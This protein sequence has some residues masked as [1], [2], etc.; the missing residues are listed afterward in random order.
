MLTAVTGHRGFIGSWLMPR[1]P[2]P[3]IGLDILEGND[4]LTCPLPDADLVIHL[5]AQPGVIASMEDPARTMLQN[6]TA[7]VRLCERYRDVPFVFASSGG[8]IQETIASPY[9]LSKK[10]CEEYL[11]LRHPQATILRFANVYGRGSRSVIDKFIRGESRVVYGDGN[12]T[13]TYVYVEDLVDGIVASIGWEPGL[14]RFGS[15]QTYT[16]NQILEAL[17][18][19]EQVAYMPFRDGELIDSFL[20]NTAPG[21]EPTMDALSYC[22]MMSPCATSAS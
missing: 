2:Q 8:T 21:W 3:T 10:M 16:V 9:G 17:G 15:D 20:E 11:Q 1:L 19:N 12:Q 14:Y 6:V 13:R 4:V 7:T 22:L 5:A 18:L